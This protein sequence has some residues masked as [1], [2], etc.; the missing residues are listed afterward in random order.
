MKILV[1]GGAGYIGSHVARMLVAQGMH[2]ITVLD[3]LVAGYAEALPDCPFVQMDLE[4]EASLNQLLAQAKFD[5]IIH[6]AAH[7]VV[8]ESVRDPL[9]Y[10]TN[11][12]INTTRLIRLAEQHNVPRFVFSSTAAVYG[13]PKTVPIVEDSLL[14]PINPY[15]WSKLMSEQ[16]LRDLSVAKPDFKHAII[17]YFNV[18][19]CDPEF[20][21]GES[22]EPETHLIPLVAK[23]ALGKRDGFAIYGDDYQTPDGTCIRDYVHV[24]DLAEAHL[25]A[26]NYLESGENL[27]VNCGYGHG[28]SVKEVVETVKKV[29]GVDFPVEIRERRLGDPDELV[30]SNDKIRSILHWEPRYD[31]LETICHHALEWERR[32]RY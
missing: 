13:M 26:L 4:D 9:K 21:I 22:H 23:A 10:Y 28:Y 11:N 14:S 27:T 20:M 17:R 2:D 18:A 5:A 25:L 12:T 32:R 15:G 8:P 31:N 3:S 29:S 24:Q 19:G 7:I 6:F 1:T 30:A 16:V